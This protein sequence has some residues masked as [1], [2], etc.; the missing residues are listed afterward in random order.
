MDDLVLFKVLTDFVCLYTYEFWL[1]LDKIVR[2]NTGTNE[3]DVNE[4][5]ETFESDIN[6][7]FDKH[8]PTKE[9]YRKIISCHTWIEPVVKFKVLKH[10]DFEFVNLTSKGEFLQFFR[11]HV[12]YFIR[13]QRSNSSIKSKR[14]FTIGIYMEEAGQHSLG[15]TYQLG[16]DTILNVKT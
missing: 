4:I 1:S 13:L 2:S 5:S 14:V 6:T 7:N 10:K 16:G 11:K 12:G 3:I 9:M 15:Q 8:V